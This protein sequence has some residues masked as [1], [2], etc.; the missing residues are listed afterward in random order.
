MNQSQPAYLGKVCSVS[1]PVH[2]LLALWVHSSHMGPHPLPGDALDGETGPVNVEKN[3][4]I[5]LLFLSRRPG[6]VVRGGG[7][8]VLVGAAAE[9]AVGAGAL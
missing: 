1:Y 9:E 7:G 3:P 4:S 6:A 8:G 5:L 2:H